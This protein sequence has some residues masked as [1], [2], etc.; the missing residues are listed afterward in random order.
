MAIVF[1]SPQHRQRVFFLGII[2][3]FLFVL[4]FI[5]L[6]VL[7]ANPKEVEQEFVF[8]RP[9][10]SVNISVLDSAVVKNLEPFPEMKIEFFYEAF[11]SQRQKTTGSVWAVSREEAI[12]TLEGLNLSVSKLTEVEIGRDNPF[13]PYY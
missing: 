5:S 1:I 9:K 6:S 10:V 8:N 7:F 2:I 13:A 12:K 4:I 11:T 3:A